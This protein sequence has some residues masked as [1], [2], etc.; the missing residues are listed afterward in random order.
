MFKGILPAL[1]TPIDEKGN[2]N[3]DALNALI[4]DMIKKGADGFYLCGATGEGLNLPIELHKDCSKEAI[5]I[6][7][8]RV[9][10][11]VHVARLDFGEAITLAKHAER[12]GAA[13]ISA[14]PPIF[15]TYDEDEIYSYYKML[16][17]SVS[18]P[19]VIYN[20]P[21]AQVTFNEKILKRLFSIPNVKGIKWTNYDFA[22]VSAVK[23][24]LPDANFI[25]GPD[26]MLLFG[27]TAGCDAGIGT[28]YNYLLPEIKGIYNAYKSGD[29]KKAQELQ[30]YVARICA[31]I[32]GKNI[33]MSTKFIMSRLGY[34]VYYPIAPMRKFTAEEEAALISK[35]RLEGM[36]IS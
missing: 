15:Y 33:I 34:D 24:K 11:I 12:V 18:I 28:T 31:A 30:S 6:I 22:T 9:P 8:G 27:L 2:L 14:I 10:A 4:N 3:K 5:K 17:E 23:A 1:I 36:N 21:N 20:N 7:D 29:L 16:S 19:V 32:K 25:N 26:Q 35:L 13:A